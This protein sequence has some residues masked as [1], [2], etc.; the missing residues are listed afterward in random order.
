MKLHRFILQFNISDGL[1]EI[2]DPEVVNQIRNVLKLKA[3]EQILLCLPAQAGDGEVNEVVGEIMELAKEVIK[4]KVIKEQKNENEPARKVTLYCAILKRENFELVVQKATEV[5]VAEIVPII[6]R[7]TVKLDVKQ[8]RLEKIIK[9][10]AEQSGRGVIPK[11]LPPQQFQEQVERVKG[12]GQNILFDSSGQFQIVNFKFQIQK[13][14]GIFVGPEGGFDET[15]IT[16]AKAAGFEISSLG[17]LTLRGETAAIVA[18]YL[19]VS[20]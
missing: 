2:T 6:T 16:A 4:V 10:A 15:E 8:E 12:K 17:K 19:A 1:V 5:G 11:L 9:E 18:S 3:G 7:R 14:C 13:S 20:G